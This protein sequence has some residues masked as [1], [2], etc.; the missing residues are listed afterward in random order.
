MKSKSCT[1]C[2][3]QLK[4]MKIGVNTMYYCSKCGAIT[5]EKFIQEP[6]SVS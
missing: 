1:R 2:S 4:R 3:C 5:S 6:I